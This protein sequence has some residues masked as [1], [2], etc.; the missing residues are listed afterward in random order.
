MAPKLPI[1]QQRIADS[2]F[3]PRARKQLFG[4][5]HPLN[6]I[7]Q[8]LGAGGGMPPINIQPSADYIDPIAPLHQAKA[9]AATRIVAG[10]RVRPNR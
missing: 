3:D 5:G 7:A 2:M 10:D 1:A 8:G 4:G 6:R 9:E